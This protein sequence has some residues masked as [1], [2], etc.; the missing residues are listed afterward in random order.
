MPS[1]VPLLVQC[2]APLLVQRLV[3]SQA[4]CQGPLQVLSL[5]PLQVQ[6]LATWHR[7]AAECQSG[8]EAGRR[9]REAAEVKAPELRRAAPVVLVLLST[10]GLHPA[11]YQVTRETWLIYRLHS[12]HGWLL[13]V[14]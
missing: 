1:L 6:C 12:Q 7:A 9:H 3:P 14:C 2:Q 13:P 5:G 10:A 11:S 4:Q 8:M